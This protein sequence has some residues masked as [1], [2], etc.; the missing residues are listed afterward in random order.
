MSAPIRHYQQGP[1]RLDELA[2]DLRRALGGQQLHVLPPLGYDRRT[3]TVYLD[4]E[5]G[6][7]P[8]Y[9]RLTGAGTA[10]GKYPWVVQVDDGNGH[11]VDGT[12]TGS[13]A[14]PNA[15][16][17]DPAVELNGNPNVGLIR[18]E[19]WRFGGVLRFRASQCG[20]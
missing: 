14:D 16:D 2:A 3:N 12:R 11:L 6:S 1:V 5:V 20:G 4:G 8:T 13:A 18:V 10:D 9:I 7:R 19:A 17:Y 15:A